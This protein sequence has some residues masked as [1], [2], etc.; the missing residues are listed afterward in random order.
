MCI[1]PDVLLDNR[2]LT[3]GVFAHEYGH[4]LDLAFGVRHKWE[5]AVRRYPEH[6]I[7]LRADEGSPA[8]WS[9]PGE[10]FARYVEQLLNPQ[11]DERGRYSKRTLA[12][13]FPVFH[14]L[15]SR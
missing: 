5:S 6:A 9:H 7:W 13:L 2:H 14:R 10:M 12:A 15:V 8:Y 1:G 4:F 3:P 11:A